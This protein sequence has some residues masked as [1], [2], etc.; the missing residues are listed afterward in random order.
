M[1]AGRKTKVGTMI[2][3]SCFLA[4]VL[5][6]QMS[7]GAIFDESKAVTYEQYASSHVIEDSVLFIGTY[8]I[9]SQSLTDELYEKAMESATDSNQMN[10][11]YK[12]ELAGGA[13]FDITDAAGLSDISDQGIMAEAQ[14][15]A[16]LWVTCYTGAD[17]ITKDAR[18]DEAVN[19]FDT[20]DPY[21]LYNLPELEPI[22]LQ[23]DNQ[24]SSDSTGVDQYYYDTLREFFQLELKN[25]VTDLCDLQL[26]GLQNCYESLQASDNKALAEIIS[27]LMS[28]IDGR[29]RAEL[30]SILSEVADNELMKL[31]NHC[32]GEGYKSKDYRGEQFVENM[33]VS[34]AVGI[35]LQSCQES[36]I[37]YSGR[38]LEQGET[39]LK[40]VEYAKSM[41][42]VE[43]ASN[44]WSGQ[45]EGMLLE[46]QALYHIQDDVIA[47]TD[48]ELSLLEGE[49]LGAAE[50]KY[51][52]L[53]SAGAGGAYQAAVANG[54]SQAAR[55]QVLDDQK[56]VVNG[57]KSEFQYLI[58]AK[59]KRQSAVDGAAY[60]YQRIEQAEGFYGL[61]AEDDFRGKAQETI[62]DHILWLQSLAKS[63]SDEDESLQSE[64]QKLE[65][66]KEELLAQQADALDD[67]N[68]SEAKRYEALIAQADQEIA[69]KEQEL[70]AVLASAS[71]TSAQKAQAA[72]Q[73]GD[74]TVLNNMNQM[75][76]DA[77]SMIA[78]GN[79]DGN[80]NFSN[81]LDGLA[82]LGAESALAEIKDKLESS[83]STRLLKDVD[84]AME[85]SRESSLHD[86]YGG[87]GNEDGIVQPGADGTG[88]GAGTGQTGT[89]DGTGQSGEDGI[90]TGDGMDQTGAD[91][92][93]SGDGTGQPGA[94]GMESG[95]GTGQPGKDETGS[96]DGTGQ[97]G[98]DGAGSGDGTGGN[99]IGTSQPGA[100]NPAAG[101]SEADIRSILETVLGS[102]FDDANDKNKAEA[103]AAM[104]RLGQSGSRAAANLAR[105]FLSQCVKEDN[106]YIFLKLR[107]ESAE[108]IP[109][110][111]IGICGGY[112]YVYSDS[113]KEVTLTKKSRVYRFSVYGDKVAVQGGKEEQLTSPVKVQSLPY[114]AE[115]DASSYFRCQAEYIDTTDYGVVLNEEMQKR[116][117]ELLSAFQEGD[118]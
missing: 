25:D 77:L 46:L 80:A 29:R 106:P 115:A 28:R 94:D 63:I 48:R 53:I 11:Y 65:S 97:P 76:N 12:S 71:S 15:L 109:L 91:G 89:G 6:Y 58:Q 16:P 70:N 45:I 103:T 107:G 98:T 84:K 57:A 75:K 21:D 42:V 64:L 8:L 26:A 102:S 52:Q 38:M 105:I 35:A 43:I 37:E 36:Y 54:V 55:N 31:K 62:D 82:S 111:S 5:C 33:D 90:K 101:M 44:G 79:A 67:N 23:Y 41:Q 72:N 117:E 60:T 118:R 14:E 114:L 18:S 1:R 116:V 32:S 100:D 56:S 85:D 113:Q 49:L 73:A 39:V 83:G 81:M 92:M 17:G 20:P 69:A 27:K 3:S 61:V 74:R 51:R 95:A 4:G 87:S 86:L 112:R 96:G 22:R 93:G 88:N 59:V 99:G 10:V 34:D 110:R 78:D 40:N 50:N 19:I 24:F 47:D 68:L 13:W 2:F 66:R 104:N 9:H 30:F 7:R 108:H